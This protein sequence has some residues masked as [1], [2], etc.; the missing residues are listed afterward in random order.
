MDRTKS[1]K[2]GE[3]H[4]EL[5]LRWRPILRSRVRPVRFLNAIQ[6][7]QALTMQA[8]VDAM[9]PAFSDARETPVRTQLGQSLFMPGR[10]P[11]VAGIKVVSTQPGNPVG[12][13]VVFDESGSPMGAVDGATLTAIR[14]GAGCGLATEL[15]AD[16]DSKV[17]AML[18]AGAMAFDQVDAVRTVRPIERILVWSRSSDHAARLADRV[19]GETVDSPDDAAAL[20]DVISTATPSTA[21]LF[22]VESVRPGAHINAVGAFTPQMVELPAGLLRASFVVVDDREA[23]SVEAGDL[24]QAGVTPDA[25]MADL[26]AG[27][28]A[29]PEGATTVFKSVGIA[30]QDVAAARAALDGAAESGIGTEIPD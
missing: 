12:I 1:G 8:C 17:H 4:T 15:L 10:I 2:N 14:T 20:A 9:R 24:I 16:P 3:E 18:G 22:A 23:A 21:P 28:S 19:G 25:A 7:R 11:G 13:V 27:R 30:S 6:T 29:A 5:P 26:L